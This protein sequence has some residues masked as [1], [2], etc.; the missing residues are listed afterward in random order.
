MYESTNEIITVPI[1]VL[2]LMQ[3]TVTSDSALETEISLCATQTSCPKICFRMHSR[4]LSQRC[5]SR[6]S[7]KKKLVRP[8]SRKAMASLRGQYP[9]SFAKVVIR[10]SSV[11]L[12]RLP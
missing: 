12:T 10:S 2:G 7:V 3:M 6:P 8:F 1:L 4:V 11:R 5:W 9:I